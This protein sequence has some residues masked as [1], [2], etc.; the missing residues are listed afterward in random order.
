MPTSQRPA[1]AGVIGRLLAAPQRFEFF[2]A[3][4]LLEQWRPGAVR[5]RNRLGMSFPPNQIENISS[6][7]TGVRV[8][9]AFMG[10]LGSQGVLP[11]HYSE[12]IGRHERSANDG[13]PRAF[14]D[15]L[16]HRPVA[17]FY[18]AWTRH[19]PECAEDAFMALLN[20]L[21]GVSRVGED[22]GG[23]ARETIAFYAMQIRARAA[24]A[25]LLEGMY[26]EYFGVPVEVQ[27]LI[28]EWRALPAQDQAQLGRAHVALDGGVMLGAR[29]YGCDGRA[30]L[31]IGPLDKGRY[32]DFLPG[33]AGAR[34]LAAMLALHCG[35]GLT[36][37]VY[38]VQRAQDMTGVRLDGGSRLGVD[39]RLQDGTATED[40]A[41]LM[42]LL[43]S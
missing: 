25:A 23:I 4:R 36:W 35:A 33:R 16:S 28:G 11:L 21:A 12:R 41:E 22:S 40:H 20:A 39:A 30:R 2:Q 18:E 9:P 5:C 34:Q 17:L 37:E 10:L 14:L 7:D 43:H 42:Y 6:D 32:E 29:C 24:P 13:G 15:L 19:R 27:P 8:T 26:S 3:M 38:L 31:R 1:A